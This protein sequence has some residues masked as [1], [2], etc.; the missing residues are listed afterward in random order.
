MTWDEYFMGMAKHVSLKSKDPSSQVGCVVVDPENQPLSWGYNG[1]ARGVPD[2]P[3]L[4]NNREVKL[5]LTLHAELNAV[6]FSDKSLR[7]ATVYVYPMSPCSQCAAVL[8]QKGVARVVAP[9]PTEAQVE[10]WGE[11]WVLAKFQFDKAGI[12]LDLIGSDSQLELDL[13][14]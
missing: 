9:A 14:R 7:G 13:G 5:R 11:D 1:F 3:E 6:L 12:Q 10:R 4:L 8:V 2:L